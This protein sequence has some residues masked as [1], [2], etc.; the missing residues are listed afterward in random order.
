MTETT[1]GL[2]ILEEEQTTLSARKATLRRIKQ[3]IETN[4]SNDELGPFY[5]SQAFNLSTRYIG[6][7]FN[8]EGTALSRFIWETRLRL[9]AKRL[10]DP[11]YAQYSISTIAY[12]HGF[13]SQSHF[14]TSFREKYR[15][16]PSEYR[17]VEKYPVGEPTAIP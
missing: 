15:C 6:R 2:F 1:L 10:L 5:V 16:S 12:L 14:S 4:I 9:A 7:L 8:E 3:F 13:K 17:S 11:M